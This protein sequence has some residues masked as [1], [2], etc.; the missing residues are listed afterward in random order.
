M[1]WAKNPNRAKV[2]KAGRKAAGLAPIS[3]MPI[4]K[5]MAII[6]MKKKYD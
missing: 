2:A 5:I 6:A 4:R 1:I 3:L